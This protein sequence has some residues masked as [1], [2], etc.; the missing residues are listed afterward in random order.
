MRAP[1]SPPRAEHRRRSRAGRRRVRTRRSSRALGGRR[2]HPSTRPRRSCGSRACRA[3]RSR[4]ARGSSVRPSW[5][6]PRSRSAPRP[7]PR[8]WIA[9]RRRC[10]VTAGAL[11][12]PTSSLP[13]SR[14]AGARAAAAVR[15]AAVRAV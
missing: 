11:R 9:A 15:A 5:P 13:R 12:P 14:V 1:P 4:A 3:R 6:P 7:T 8:G 10:S 2:A